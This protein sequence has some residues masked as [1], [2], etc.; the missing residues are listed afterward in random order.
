[1]SKGFNE[2][3]VVRVI[4][5]LVFII[6][7]V[8]L[9]FAK[10]LDLIVVFADKVVQLA[11]VRY[12][13]FT[14]QIALQS[15]KEDQ[16][17]WNIIN[18]VNQNVLPLADVLMPLLFFMA[19]FTML[20]GVCIFSFPRYFADLLT[21]LKVLKRGKSC[22]EDES[23]FEN[24]VPETLFK[25]V[26]KWLI[27]LFVLIF[28]FVST[29]LVFRC[30]TDESDDHLKKEAEIM[31]QASIFIEK[32]KDYFNKNNTVGTLKQLNL[33][34]K[35]SEHFIYSISKDGWR[36]TVKNKEDWEKCP[37]GSEWRVSVSITG[38][39][40]QKINFY[41]ALPKNT[42]CAEWTKGF[43]NVGKPLPKSEKK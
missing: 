23:A 9:F 33:E 2:Y 31:E 24:A 32:Q 12:S 4:G 20:I 30:A 6:G 5:T 43:K 28:I 42:H 11:V 16:E 39:F 22:L 25:V 40:E 19:I 41:R 13:N 10:I 3:R 21:T 8:A 29:F 26:F 34:L 7:A 17:L 38:F 37:A 35:D 18:S 36:W 15:F 1:M 27:S 14:G